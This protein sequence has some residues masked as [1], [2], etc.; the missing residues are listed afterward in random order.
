MLSA[1]G[2]ILNEADL[3]HF[4]YGSRVALST[5]SPIRYLLRPKT[6][7]PVRRLHLLSGREFHPL[8]APGLSWRTVVQVDVSQQRRDHRTLRRPLFTGT[9]LPVFQD[10]GLEPLAHQPGDA[11]VA[12]TVLHEA[13]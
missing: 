2:Q 1:C 10:P 7:F 11:L 4:R 6:R 5:L 9:P 12:N 8:E 3:L 13:Q